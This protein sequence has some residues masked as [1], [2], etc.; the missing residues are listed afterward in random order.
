[1]QKSLKTLSVLLLGTLLY[2]GCQ[3]GHDTTANIDAAVSDKA[4]NLKPDADDTTLRQL[5]Q[6]NN[7]F[8]FDLFTKLKEDGGENLFFSPLSIS[9]ALAMTYA[10]AKGETKSQMKQVLHFSMDDTALHNSFNALDL[11][12]NYTDANYTFTVADSLW[13]QKDFNLSQSYL[14]TLKINYGADVKLVD[15]KK[16]TEDARVAINSWVEEQTHA[17]I[18]DLIP[19]G[20]LT[21]LTRFVLTNAVYFKAKWMDPFEKDLTHKANFFLENDDVGLQTDFMQQTLYAAYAESDDYQALELLYR[22]ERSSMLI[23]LPREGK[24]SQTEENLSAIYPA[25]NAELAYERVHLELPKFEFTTDPYFL[26]K[27]FKALGMQVPFSDDADFSGMTGKPLMI[28]EI[29]HKAYIKV[30]EESTE[31][32]AATAV[33]GVGGAAGPQDPPV[34][35]IVNRPFLFFIKD[36]KSDQILFMGV[37]K[38]PVNDSGA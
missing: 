14:D 10:G 15:Y 28:S 7:A 21:P 38:R 16:H 30:D 37:V 18:K 35:M 36:Q 24:L 1:M 8:A 26:K 33:I 29:I 6:N 31:A 12:L 17:R 2:T 22:G 13:A 23:L 5:A 32:A 4:R 20:S 25:L 3:S 34:E 9:E 11:H 27:H 19:K